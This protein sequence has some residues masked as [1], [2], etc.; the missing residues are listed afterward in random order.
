M[1]KLFVFTSLLALVTLGSAWADQAKEEEVIRKRHAE[2]VDAW[3]RHDAKA[4]GALWADDGDLIDPAGKHAS[5]PTEIE[6]FFQG[7]H[8]TTMKG[9]TYS[10]TVTTIRF[11]TSYVAVVDVDAVVT[12]MKAADGT[13]APPLKHHVTWVAVKRRG[14][15]MALA[16]RPAVPVSMGAPAAK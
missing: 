5:G 16:A 9:T 15:W 6:R 8:S 10:G 1:K 4:L 7:E 11:P 13:D 12:G 2:F 3:N 14:Q